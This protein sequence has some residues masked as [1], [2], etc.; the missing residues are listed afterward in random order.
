LW[1]GVQPIID[2]LAGEPDDVVDRAVSRLRAGGRLPSPATVVVV[3]SSPDLE[4]AGEN[5]VR[6]RRV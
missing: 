1:W 3:R 2:E 4:R 6:V 5:F